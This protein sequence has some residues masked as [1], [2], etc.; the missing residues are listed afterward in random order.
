MLRSRR[1]AEMAAA[2]DKNHIDALIPT[3]QRVSDG[4]MDRFPSS[5]GASLISSFDSIGER[6]DVATPGD[7][8]GDHQTRGELFP[9]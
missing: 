6:F 8:R 1:G 2:D 4:V 3:E 7:G 5:S 9:F